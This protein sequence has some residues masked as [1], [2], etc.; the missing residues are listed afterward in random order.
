MYGLDVSNWQK[1]IDLDKISYDALIAKCTEGTKFVDPCCHRFVS[2]AL[3]LN[4][5]A[6]VYHYVTGTDAER[7]ASHF[8]EQAQGYVGKCIL[9]LD[10]EPQGNSAW[11]D[12]AYLERMIGFV[13]DRTGVIPFVYASARSFPFSLCQRHGCGRWVAQYESNRD[14]GYQTSPWN[15]GAYKCEIRQYTSNGRLEGYPYSLDLDKVY[16]SADEWANFAKGTKATPK[17]QL[18]VDG[19]WGCATTAALQ[20]ALG[21]PADGLISNQRTRYRKH[22]PA[23]LRSTLS[24]NWVRGSVVIRHLQDLL[25]I[26]ND[27]IIGPATVEAMQKWLGVDADGICGPKTV[28]AMQERLNSEPSLA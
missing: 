10:W 1:D 20:L 9:V 2:H 8:I 27:G 17:S 19:K 3:S 25:G 7:E 12:E 22:F 28:M 11:K 6:G 18:D 13:T 4:R 16:I 23:I 5:P 26:K 14:T 21:T 24:F 15:E